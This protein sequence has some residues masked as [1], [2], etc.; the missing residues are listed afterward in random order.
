[1]R[2]A[3]LIRCKK[4][5]C[6]IWLL[7]D[8]ESESIP[9]QLACRWGGGSRNVACLMCR[10]VCEY[11]VEDCKWGELERCK[12]EIDAERAVYLFSLPCGQACCESAMKILV[13]V[14]RK[15][16]QLH[17]KAVAASLFTRN[18]ACDEGHRNVGPVLDLSSID[19]VELVDY[20][21]E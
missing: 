2:F 11:S 19:F 5:F 16:T 3:P 10:Y 1:M 14:R 13:I 15:A 4:C 21:R 8:V 7:P 12:S 17:A 20:G 6:N 18:T 9:S